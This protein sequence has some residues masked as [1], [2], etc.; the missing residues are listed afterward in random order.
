MPV[1][2]HHSNRSVSCA[3]ILSRNRVSGNPGAVQYLLGCA[4]TPSSQGI[5]SPAI[6]RRF[7]DRPALAPG[8]SLADPRSES[9]CCSPLRLP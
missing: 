6:P 9:F 4:I 8:R 2:R 3:P 5:V 7:I 1:L